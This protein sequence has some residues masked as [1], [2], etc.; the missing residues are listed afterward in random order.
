VHADA[1]RL[2]LPAPVR[3]VLEMLEHAGFPAVALGVCVRELARGAAPDA[4]EIAARASFAEL[5]ALFPRGV[6]MGPER[7]GLASAAG[8]ID[9]LPRHAAELGEELGQ[10]DFSIHAMALARD[11]A[12]H[13]PHGGRADLDAGILRATLDPDA[14]FAEDPV[15]ALRAARLVAELGFSLASDTQA[16][17]TRAAHTV[18]TAHP[19]RLRSE[20]GRLLLADGAAEGLRC[21]RRL[22]IEAVLAPGVADDAASLVERLPRDLDLRLAAWLRDARAVATL[23]A[24]RF[25]RGRIWRVERLLQL[26]PIEAGPAHA[27]EQRVRRLARRSE[28]DLLGLIAL[29]EAEIAVRG[30]GEAAT[31]RLQPVRAAAARALRA[32]H[33]ADRRATLAVDGEDVKRHLGVGPGAHVGQA[34]RHLA[35]QIAEDPQRNERETLLALLDA[36]AA[37]RAGLG[38]TRSDLA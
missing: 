18:T 38:A 3:G 35:E 14:R 13:D 30:E 24:L 11:G 36:W 23:R 22:G 20:I 25:P 31:R 1:L 26:H 17:A 12:L 33:L 2:P 10:R 32:D 6:V 9:V 19:A 37:A 16:A 29:R 28:A 4:F 5:L 8:P 21:L 15:R 7:L 34:L 27:R